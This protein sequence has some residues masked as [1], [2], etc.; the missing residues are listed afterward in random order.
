[1]QRNSSNLDFIYKMKGPLCMQAQWEEEDTSQDHLPELLL[2]FFLLLLFISKQC[3]MSKK[4]QSHLLFLLFLW[5]FFL[6]I[7]WLID[8]LIDSGGSYH[9]GLTLNLSIPILNLCFSGLFTKNLIMTRNLPSTW[10]CSASIPSLFPHHRSQKVIHFATLSI[11]YG[12]KT[13][14]H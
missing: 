11:S 4:S 1:M 12:H 14:W 7:D 3:C 5:S 6:L 10:P 2:G 13:L 8:W 9:P